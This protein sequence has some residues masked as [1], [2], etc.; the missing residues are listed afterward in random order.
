MLCAFYQ[1]YDFC[2]MTASVIA[3]L[4]VVLLAAAGRISVTDRN[5]YLVFAGVC[6]EHIL[7][8]AHAAVCGYEVTYSSVFGVKTDFG[9]GRVHYETRYRI[10]V[11]Y[12]DYLFVVINIP[13]SIDCRRLA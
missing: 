8:H 2:E 1:I 10:I 5:Y 6:I 13:V 9:P 11:F 4:E 3:N 7:I 12:I